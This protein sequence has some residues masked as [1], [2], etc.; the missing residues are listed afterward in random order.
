M[1]RRALEGKEKVLGPEYPD[2]LSSCS[3]LGLV[4]WKQ[5]K[6]KEADAMH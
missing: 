6:Y 3:Y 2:T 4:L 5:G 1:H